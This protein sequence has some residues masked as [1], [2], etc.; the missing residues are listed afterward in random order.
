[1]VYLIN[2]I[3]LNLYLIIKSN[4]QILVKIKFYRIFLKNFL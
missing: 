1:M 2:F 4:K 3:D